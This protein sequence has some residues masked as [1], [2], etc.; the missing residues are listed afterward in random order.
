MIRKKFEEGKRLNGI[1]SESDLHKAKH[2]NYVQ[3]QY[4]P[5]EQSPA[6]RLR[7]SW[8]IVLYL[9]PREEEM[10]RDV[11]MQT[12]P[13][14]GQNNNSIKF[15]NSIGCLTDSVYF[16]LQLASRRSSPAWMLVNFGTQLFH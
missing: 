8:N 14:P 15:S 4:R 5:G 16:S 1:R 9:S 13:R 10:R 11:R 2:Q 7:K 3:S 12:V 6:I